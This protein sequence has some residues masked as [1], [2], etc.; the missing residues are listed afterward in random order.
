[1]KAHG[2]DRLRRRATRVLHGV[3][4]DGEAVSDTEGLVAVLARQEFAIDVPATGR[5]LHV[6]MG[7]TIHLRDEPAAPD[8]P[9]AQATHRHRV[10]MICAARQLGPLVR[11]V[12]MVHE[13]SMLQRGLPWQLVARTLCPELPQVM[14]RV[15]VRRHTPLAEREPAEQGMN[16][17]IAF[18]RPGPDSF[19]QR[20]ELGADRV[21][22]RRVGDQ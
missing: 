7:W 17:S 6:A 2:L 22:G 14:V 4:V 19:H 21:D 15:L 3:A 16:G 9:G 20:H 18:A 8:T 10:L 11:R 5:G 13:A 12:V 1:M